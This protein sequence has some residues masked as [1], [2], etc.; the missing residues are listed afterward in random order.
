MKLRKLFEEIENSF[1]LGDQIVKIGDWVEIDGYP[2]QIIGYKGRFGGEDTFV[3]DDNQLP[4]ANR[5]IWADR[6]DNKHAPT[7]YRK[8]FY[9]SDLNALAETI[10]DI[11]VYSKSRNYQ[12]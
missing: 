11:E 6:P 9:V 12:W 10:P 2:L 4:D 7:E 8:A 3:L 1:Q 5:I